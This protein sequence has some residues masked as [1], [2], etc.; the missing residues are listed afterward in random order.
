MESLPNAVLVTHDLTQS[1]KNYLQFD[2]IFNAGCVDTNSDNA[3]ELELQGKENLILTTDLNLFKSFTE[4]KNFVSES[5]ESL[6]TEQ[7]RDSSLCSSS[8]V[9]RRKDGVEVKEENRAAA[10]P[11]GQIQPLTRHLKQMQ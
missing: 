6:A 9:A 3:N 4:K 11:S 1:K 8:S 5:L 2:M 7:L 10:F